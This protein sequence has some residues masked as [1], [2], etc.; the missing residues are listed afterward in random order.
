[1]IISPKL[2]SHQDFEQIKKQEEKFKNEYRN[3]NPTKVVKSE[4]EAISKISNYLSK[5]TPQKEKFPHPLPNNIGT[6]YSDWLKDKEKKQK[7]N[8]AKISL[9][10]RISNLEYEQN[11]A[12]R[13]QQ[14]PKP[15]P[16][17]KQ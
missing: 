5:K 2:Y 13:Y 4:L 11:R 7:L 9:D 3:A 6:P 16:K 8:R 17:S 15:K 12:K 10:M 1:M 14:K